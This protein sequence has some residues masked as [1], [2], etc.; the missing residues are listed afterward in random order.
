MKSTLILARQYGPRTASTLKW[1]A[2]FLGGTYC[3]KIIIDGGVWIIDEDVTF[4]SNIAVE[5]LPDA[6]INVSAGKTFIIESQYY[7]V[8][9]LVW[10]TGAG[11]I[12]VP[13][14][15]AVSVAA[16]QL[17]ATEKDLDTILQSGEYY[18]SMADEVLWVN[19]PSGSETGSAYV[20]VVRVDSTTIQ[21]IFTPDET[22]EKYYVR[23]LSSGIWSGW[24][25]YDTAAAAATYT[26][27]KAESEAKNYA[28][29]YSGAVVFASAAAPQISTEID[30]SDKIGINRAFVVLRVFKNGSD[31]NARLYGFLNSDDGSVT[32][33][34]NQLSL[35]SQGEAYVSL[36]TSSAGTV[37]WI[38]NN[39]TLTT[40]YLVAYQVLQ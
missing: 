28:M 17:T 1:I 31:N 25:I 34:K 36:I 11:T 9:K 29:Q 16:T 24:A 33:F 14:P 38:S 27:T 30:L 22:V 13:N 3:A 5:I 32:I 6:T 10:W 39:G 23:T 18:G 15:M 4:L 21:Q 8:Y 12:S 2:T 7:Q 19:G 26:D 35:G 40:I 20:R 37:N